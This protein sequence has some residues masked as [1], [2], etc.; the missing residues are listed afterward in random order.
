MSDKVTLEE[1][2][3]IAVQLSPY[4]QLKLIAWISENLSGLL[5]LKIT[6]CGSSKTYTKSDADGTPSME[7]IYNRLTAQGHICFLPKLPGKPFGFDELEFEKEYGREELLRIK[8]I[9]TLEHFKKIEASDAVLIVNHSRERD[10]KFIEGYFGS[11]T[12]MELAVAY[13]LRK[14]IYILKPFQENHPHYEEIAKLDTII[15][16]G[17]LSKIRKIG[18]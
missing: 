1:A 12:L 5:P 11:N 4:D 3:R 2:E 9:V 17:D 13:Y 6:F 7:E 16:N 15:L 8:P 10:G 18:D 14:K